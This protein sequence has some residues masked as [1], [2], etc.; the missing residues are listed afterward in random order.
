M[1][2]A[3]IIFSDV[4]QT[5]QAT[6]YKPE[7]VYSTFLTLEQFYTDKPKGVNFVRR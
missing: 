5:P 1:K 4:R 7:L 3:C 2:F 6:S